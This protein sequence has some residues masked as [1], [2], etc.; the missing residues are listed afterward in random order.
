MPEPQHIPGW[1]RVRVAQAPD[2]DQQVAT[3]PPN[4]AAWMLPPEETL[5][6]AFALIAVAR[7]LFPDPVQLDAAAIRAY[8]SHGPLSAGAQP[9]RLGA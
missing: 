2:G 1:I 8:G 6:Y 4:G 5:A 3:F 7:N 9:R